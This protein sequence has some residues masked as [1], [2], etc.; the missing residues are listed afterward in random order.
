MP[1]ILRKFPFS[2]WRG[3]ARVGTEVQAGV[4]VWGLPAPWGI[5][6]DRHSMWVKPLMLS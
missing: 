4:W 3:W 5:L 6:G 1:L 2:C